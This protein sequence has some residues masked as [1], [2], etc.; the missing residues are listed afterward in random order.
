MGNKIGN[1]QSRSIL[2]LVN[3]DI[4]PL[5]YYRRN[6]SSEPSADEPVQKAEKNVLSSKKS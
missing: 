5:E 6:R 4:D 2:Y 3:E 1:A